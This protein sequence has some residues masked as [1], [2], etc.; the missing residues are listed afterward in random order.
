MKKILNISFVYFILAMVGGVFYREFTKILGFNGKTTLAYVH[1]HLLVL[2]TFL[3]L[4]IA[5]FC[6]DSELLDNRRFQQFLIVYNVSLPLMVCM[7]L[8]RGILQATEFEVTNAMNGMIAGIAGISHIFLAISLWMLFS[9]L[10]Q[11]FVNE[12]N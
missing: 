1:V 3:F 5:L 8:I 9:S 11:V 6:R 7:L 10:K 4:I 2:G 12:N